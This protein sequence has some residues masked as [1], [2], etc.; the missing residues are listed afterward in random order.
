[1]PVSPEVIT[2]RE[3]L[4]P[5]DTW[6]RIWT[7]SEFDHVSDDRDSHHRHLEE[8]IRSRR[9]RL[10]LMIDNILIG[11]IVKFPF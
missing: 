3:C 7:R 11:L 5:H 8:L 1:M 10:I 4:I 6:W 2:L 9:W